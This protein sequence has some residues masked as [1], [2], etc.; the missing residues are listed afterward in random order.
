MF[1]VCRN[2]WWGQIFEGEINIESNVCL[3]L[4][5]IC[6]AMNYLLIL[7]IHLFMKF[8]SVVF[9]LCLHTLISFSQDSSSVQK[10]NI[11]GYKKWSRNQICGRL[12]MGIQKSGY[13]E[14]GVS[15]LKYYF[16][17]LGYAAK[18]TYIAF[19]W[20]YGIPKHDERRVIGFKIGHEINLRSLALGIESKYLT[21][22][23]KSD[24]VITPKIGLGMMGLLNIFYGYNISL[25]NNPFADIKQNQVSLVINLNRNIL[26]SLNQN[27]KVS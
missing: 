10:N 25:E 6:H 26:K 14:L 12:G 18:N 23:E 1:G 9:I 17:D 5:I 4:N 19:E 8:Y 11:E 27:K 13:N 7:N 21:D 3:Y 15:L 2:V 24:F 20:N 16:N 22:N